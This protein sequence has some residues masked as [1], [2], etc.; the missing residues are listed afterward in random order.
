M[1]NKVIEVLDYLGEK[2]GIA[3]DWTAENV[4][5]QVT[6]F[7]GRYATYE[8][9]RSIVWIVIGLITIIASICLWRTMYKSYKKKDGFWYWTNE[10]TVVVSIITVIASVVFVCTI[11]DSIFK[12]IEWTIIPE[13]KFVEVISG[14]LKSTG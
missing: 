11:E 10:A 6:E 12:I 9:A 13:M 5:P 3:V 2:F 7:M 8:I 14:L 1:D 4:W